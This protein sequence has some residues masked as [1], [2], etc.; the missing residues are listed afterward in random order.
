M[1]HYIFFIPESSTTSIKYKLFDY[2]ITFVNSQN[3]NTNSKD[4]LI[5][6][7]Q[8]IGFKL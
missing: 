1:I 3:E 2:K 4:Y 7:N 8:K 6:F 5:F